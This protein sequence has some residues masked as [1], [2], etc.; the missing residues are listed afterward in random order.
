[1]TSLLVA[2]QQQEYSHRQIHRR[3]VLSA[4][5]NHYSIKQNAIT[6]IRRQKKIA[7]ARHVAMFLLKDMIQLS[8]SEIGQ[9]FSNRDHTSVIHGVNKINIG[10]R[11]DEVLRQDVEAIKTS[12]LGGK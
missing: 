12:I 1:V 5:A 6:G 10:C 11:S 4:V 3:E 9:L 2:E 8:Y 7:L